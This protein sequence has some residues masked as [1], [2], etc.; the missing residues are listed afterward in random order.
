M[1]L[2][3]SI[4]EL[5][6]T[7]GTGQ[8]YLVAYGEHGEPVEVYV[9]DYTA[10]QIVFGYRD[11]S[12]QW[13]DTTIIKSVKLIVVPH[14]MDNSI[15]RWKNMIL[16]HDGQ[17]NGS[18]DLCEIYTGPDGNCNNKVYGHCP[19]RE[20][21]GANQC[22]NTSYYDWWQS[23]V[24]GFSTKDEVITQALIMLEELQIIKAKINI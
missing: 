7:K 6:N 2:D 9:A 10:R 3:H 21:T 14:V 4:Q 5:K 13:I 1:S 22:R 19:I 12:L 11:Q 23:T 16:K 8:L 24:D 17:D 15:Q 20:V 18:C